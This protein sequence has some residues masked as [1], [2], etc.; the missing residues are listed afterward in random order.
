MLLKTISTKETRVHLYSR[1]LWHPCK[2]LFRKTLKGKN[3]YLH[4][5][6][7][8]LVCVHFK[9]CIICTGNQMNGNTPKC[10]RGY[11]L[12]PSHLCAN[13]G[14]AGPAL[15]LPFFRLHPSPCS[16]PPSRAKELLTLQSPGR[17]C[18]VY[19]THNYCS[20]S[21]PFVQCKCFVKTLLQNNAFV[22]VTS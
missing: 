15:L 2:V 19:K 22:T 3:W 10:Y 4:I 13:S 17:A 21:N 7:F 8:K 6:I 20:H 16:F 12:P 11:P 18:A 9:V 5:L 14:P 1:A